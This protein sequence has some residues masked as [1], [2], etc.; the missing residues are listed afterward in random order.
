MP[1]L[2]SC[3]ANGGTIRSPLVSQ[4]PCPVLVA[5]NSK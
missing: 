3:N 5:R 4:N 1:G 2:S